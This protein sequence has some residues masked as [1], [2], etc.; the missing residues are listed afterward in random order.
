MRGSV[1]CA[2]ALSLL[3]IAACGGA[4]G[5]QGEMPTQESLRRIPSKTL[6]DMGREFA[7]KGDHLRAAQYLTIVFDRG[8]EPKLV[9]SALMNVYVS[10]SRFRDAI[11]VA[12]R[13]LSQDPYDWRLHL[14][15]AA[16]AVSVN[17]GPKATQHVGKAIAQAPNDA[18]A[19]YLAAVVARDFATDEARA[20]AHF[21]RYLE[22][23]PT[24]AHAAEAR[25]YVET[26]ESSGP[27]PVEIPYPDAGVPSPAPPP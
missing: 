23:D 6:Y 15:V 25:A 14:V 2:L 11:E 20:R 1:A 9:V 4:D 24:G 16:L 8:Y 18:A 12:D 22:L 27:A 13:R 17:D 7:R 10:T 5:P 26:L 19:N 3:L 21:A